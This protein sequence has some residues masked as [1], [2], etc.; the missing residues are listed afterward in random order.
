MDGIA[1][2]IKGIL[3]D[4]ATLTTAADRQSRVL[5]RMGWDLTDDGGRT[6]HSV[7]ATAT[8]AAGTTSDVAITWGRGRE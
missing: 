7:A 1:T 8:A 6:R 4:F 2:E 3:R 5:S